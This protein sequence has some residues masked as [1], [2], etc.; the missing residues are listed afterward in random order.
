[1]FSIVLEKVWPPIKYYAGL[2]QF[3]IVHLA[4][5]VIGLSKY[6]SLSLT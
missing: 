2:Y 1:M 3:V 6:C 5:F 4:E